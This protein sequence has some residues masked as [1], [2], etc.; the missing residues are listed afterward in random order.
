MKKKRKTSGFLRRICTGFLA[1]AVAV[2]LFSIFAGPAGSL[3]GGVLGVQDVYAG[4]GLNPCGDNLDCAVGGDPYVLS[5]Y[6]RDKNDMNASRR[7]MNTYP[8]N[9]SPPGEENFPWHSQ[10]SMIEGVDIGNGVRSII[11]NAFKNMPKLKKVYLPKTIEYISQDAFAGCPNITDVY[12]YGTQK[13]WNELLYDIFPGN[14]SLTGANIHFLDKGAV[15]YDFRSDEYPSAAFHWEYENKILRKTLS[16]LANSWNNIIDWDAD[17]PYAEAVDLDWD[18]TT[19]LRVQF[20]SGETNM[21]MLQ[22]TDLHNMTYTIPLDE[23]TSFLENEDEYYSSVTFIFPP[24]HNGDMGTYTMMLGGGDASLSGKDGFA[25]MLYLQ[26]AINTDHSIYA[27]DPN[28]PTK[29]DVDRSGSMDLGLTWAPDYQVDVKVLSTNSLSHMYM[30][31]LSDGAKEYINFMEEWYYGTIIFD[32]DNIG[33][34]SNTLNKKIQ[35]VPVTHAEKL[36][37]S[38]SPANASSKNV[39]W[40][41]DRPEVAGVD[42]S[43]KVFGKKVGKARVFAKAEA[44][45]LSDHCNVTV[46]FHDVNDTG[47]YYFDPVYWAVDHGIT[48]GKSETMFNPSDSCTRAQIVTFLWHAAGDPEPKT[49]KNPFKDV[50]SSSYYY[51][52]VLWAVEKG[53]TTG[54]SSTTFSPGNPCTRAQSVTFL[55]NAK[56]K[57]ANFADISFKDVKSSA[58]YY[59]A[60]RWAVKTGVTAGVSA[61]EFGSG[62]TCTRAQIV[63]FLEKA[64]G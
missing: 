7:Y 60:V 64:F 23:N 41:S 21:F 20:W 48:T 59:N 6:V 17:N 13:E 15:T 37:A 33:V 24:K 43:G 51:K 22:G 49:T 62:R 36:T 12:F 31:W 1:A 26:E 42:S 54:T 56:G 35:N 29:L 53:I 55:Y 39:I 10:R 34:S 11:R 8:P 19:D 30:K 32:F 52:P 3:T 63:T 2:S 5:I 40:S 44:G 47:K 58:Y 28:V 38:L 4:D 46:T 27:D 9:I 18:G 50:S 57:P 16:I 61:T 14:E 45:G 25:F